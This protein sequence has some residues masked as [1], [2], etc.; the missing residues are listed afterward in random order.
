MTVEQIF[1]LYDDKAGLQQIALESEQWGGRIQT[2]ETM[3]QCLSQ[4]HAC[5]AE[6]VFALVCQAD[7]VFLHIN[8]LR[9][10][11]P[12]AGVIVVRRDKMAGLERGHLLLA[13]ADACFDQEAL[14]VEVVACV[15]ALRR[16]GYALQRSLRDSPAE[17]VNAGNIAYRSE[18]EP[19]SQLWDLMENGWT[20]ITPRGHSVMLTRGERRIVQVLFAVSPQTVERDRLF[21]LEDG[22]EATARSVDVLISRLKRKLTA[23]GEELPIRSVR[24]EGYAFVGKVPVACQELA[25]VSLNNDEV[26][27]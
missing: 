16:R 15:Q 27:E 18:Q 25:R 8:R 12:A 13:G 26:Y 11:F 21:P 10:D 2:V 1:L 24:G 4:A 23:M 6:T 3:E 7:N 5:G 19:D 9:M 14:P 22:R 17:P 20:M